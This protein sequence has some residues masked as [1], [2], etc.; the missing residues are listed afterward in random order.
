MKTS[1]LKPRKIL[2]ICVTA[3]ALI[4]AVLKIY[5]QQ[6]DLNT[7]PNKAELAA[8]AIAAAINEGHE[9]TY[10]NFWIDYSKSNFMDRKSKNICT[11]SRT[12]LIEINGDSLLKNDTSWNKHGIL[13]QGL[14]TIETA[15]RFGNKVKVNVSVLYAAEAGKGFEITLEKYGNHYRV[16]EQH[17]TWIS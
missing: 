8:L 1:I 11:S 12:F 13:K 7:L 17:I 5:K 6:T 15:Y 14:F 10:Y 9:S 4:I 3:F 16:I 2:I